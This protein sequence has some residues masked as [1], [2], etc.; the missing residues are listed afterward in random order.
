M[1]FTVPLATESHPSSDYHYSFTSECLDSMAAQAVGLPVT[2]NFSGMPIGRV[3]SAERIF[4]GLTPTAE[5]DD[6]S[7]VEAAYVA[8]GNIVVV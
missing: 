8:E 7:D 6:D 1:K 3:V 4:F 5:I 2:V